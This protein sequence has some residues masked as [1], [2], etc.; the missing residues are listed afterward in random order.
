MPAITNGFRLLQSSYAKG[1]NKQES[2]NGNL[3]QQ[4]TKAKL[5]NGGEDDSLTVFYYI[6]HNPIKAGLSIT[7]EG[8]EYSSFKDYIGIRNVT[9][10][11]KQRC[12]DLLGLSVID[13]K[14][15]TLKVIDE[16]KVKRIFL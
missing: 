10:C 11:N 5:V 7:P 4:K 12:I 8:W 6:H 14:T 3:F 16:E 1:I 2:R 15:E 9:L 13:F